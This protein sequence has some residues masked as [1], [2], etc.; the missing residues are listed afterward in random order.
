MK[1]ELTLEIIKSY[2]FEMQT[3]KPDYDDAGYHLILPNGLILDTFFMLNGEPCESDSLE[4]LDGFIYITTKEELDE[5]VNMT[6]EQ[7]VDKIAGE[8]ENFDPEE[9]I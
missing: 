7:V 4:G 3:F 2:N 9:Y 8:N 6:F 1:T 5:L